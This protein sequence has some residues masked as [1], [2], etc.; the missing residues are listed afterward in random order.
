M[1]L[2]PAQQDDCA[3]QLAGV[4]FVGHGFTVNLLDSGMAIINHS[5]ILAAVGQIDSDWDATLN[6]AV[7]AYG[8]TITIINALAASLPSP[9]SGLSGQQ[10]TVIACAVLLKR[11]GLI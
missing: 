11:A 2:T 4:M 7:S 9:S 1:A 8:G 6:Q 10:K 3:R 5:D